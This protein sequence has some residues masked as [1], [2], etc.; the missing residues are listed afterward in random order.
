MIE[1]ARDVAGLAMAYGPAI[2]RSLKTAVRGLS[3]VADEARFLTQSA[4]VTYAENLI[5]RFARLKTFFIRNNPVPLYD[6]Y[7]PAGVTCEPSLKIEKV[8]LH[9]L[10]VVGRRIIISGTGGSGK[11]IL[12]RHLLLNCLASAQ[13]VPVFIE[14][15]MFNGNGKPL[16]DVVLESFTENGFGLDAE[17]VNRL[18]SA[19]RVAFFLDG[20]DELETEV[21]RSIE[22]QINALALGTSCLI[23]VSSRPDHSLDAWA[24][25]TKVEISK[26]SLELACEL[27]QKVPFDPAVKESFLR[28]LKNGL[29]ESHEYFLSNPLLLSIML[30]TYSESA[31]IPNRLSTFYQQAYEALFQRHDALKFGFQRERKT[32]LDIHQFAR[33]FSAFSLVSYDERKFKFSVD[34]ALNSTSKASRLTDI[35]VDRQAF[36]DDARQA[37][38]LLV[39]EGL[40]LGYSHRSFQEYFVAK[41]IADA[42]G[43]SQQKLV[44]RYTKRPG[45]H[46]SFDKVVDLLF[47]MN[48]SIVEEYWLIPIFRRLFP[49]GALNR[50]VTYALWF[51]FLTRSY[52]VLSLERQHIVAEKSGNYDH[53][54]AVLFTFKNCMSEDE[55]KS[56]KSMPGGMSQEEFSAK[57]LAKGVK[58]IKLADAAV[59]SEMIRDLSKVFGIMSR[60][61]LDMVRVT[62][63]K[64]LERREARNEELIALLS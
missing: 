48:P 29:Y 21:R 18:I 61:G 6:F 3:R 44:E 42:T 55:R 37:V 4:H 30:L 40:E 54:N 25:F 64:M 24:D 22:R 5:S 1:G 12:M 52:K 23:F 32:L 51:K 35:P 20:F 56:L 34:Y 59:D 15:R 63:L 33:V 8:N 49:A 50:R 2:A 62:Y 11:T 16:I 19:G 26:L 9:D 46:F 17:Y 39:E 41:F 28:E 45:R 53:L 43:D 60:E 36:V 27:V 10:E 13:R 14:L 7:V 31:S 47:E 58:D 57:Y 38:C